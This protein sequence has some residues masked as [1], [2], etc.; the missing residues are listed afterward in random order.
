M[1]RGICFFLRFSAN[2]ACCDD[3]N[4]SEIFFLQPEEDADP[5]MRAFVA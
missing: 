5:L 1:R 2:C 4:D 3:A